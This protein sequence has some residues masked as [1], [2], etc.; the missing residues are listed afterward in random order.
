MKRIIAN[1]K[2][3]LTKSHRLYTFSNIVI[4]PNPAVK[5]VKFSG[6]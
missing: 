6:R 1:N 2:K 3:G 5:H 4:I